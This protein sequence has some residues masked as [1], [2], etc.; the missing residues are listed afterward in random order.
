MPDRY[1]NQAAVVARTQP[2][3]VIPGTPFSTVTVNNTYPTGVH[4]D[5]GDLDSGF[6]TLSCLRRGSYTGGVLV[7]PRYRVAA[8]M[9]DG[10]LLLM[11][12]HEWHGNT[13]I[14]PFHDASVHGDPEA[15]FRPMPD[16]CAGCSA[17]RITVVAYY[18]TRLET[19]G[20]VR[21]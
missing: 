8:D 18:R 10:D 2:E 16:E 14:R 3:W 20:T 13:R 4:K 19:C 5:A 17:E 11:D 1:A 15:D 9:Q 7:W 12:A 21:A 6:S